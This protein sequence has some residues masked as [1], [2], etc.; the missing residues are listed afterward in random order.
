MQLLS[1]TC[2]YM[3]QKLEPKIPT[4][5]SYSTSASRRQL[6]NNRQPCSKVIVEQYPKPSTMLIGFAGLGFA[7]RRRRQSA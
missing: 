2:S 7:A 1:L 4:S 6:N 5:R 3:K